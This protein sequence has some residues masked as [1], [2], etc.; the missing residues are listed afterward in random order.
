MQLYTSSRFAH[1]STVSDLI[2][3]FWHHRLQPC[4]VHSLPKW[5]PTSCK[6]SSIPTNPTILARSQTCRRQIPYMFSA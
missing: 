2:S 4:K 5:F 6:V 3:W 1:C